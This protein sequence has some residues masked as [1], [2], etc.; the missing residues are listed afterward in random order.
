MQTVAPKKQ[1][2]FATSK[3]SDAMVLGQDASM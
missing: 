3:N 2:R 1:N